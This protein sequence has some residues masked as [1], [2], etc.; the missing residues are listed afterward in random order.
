M[1]A[2]VWTP[3]KARFA[4]WWSKRDHEGKHFWTNVAIGV[5]LTLVLHVAE[6]LGAFAAFK[7]FG[8]DWQIATLAGVHSGPN[9]ALI[10]I[11][12]PSELSFGDRGMPPPF[13]TPRDKLARLIAAAVNAGAAAVVVDIDLSEP[14]GDP[15]AEAYRETTG[16]SARGVPVE[17]MERSLRS[18]AGKTASL[19][20][21]QRFFYGDWELSEFLRAYA[22]GCAGKPF[23]PAPGSCV[24]VILPRTVGESTAESRVALPSFLDGAIGANSRSVFWG[25]VTFDHDPDFVVRRWRLW[26]PACTP[27]GASGV[28]P[29]SALLAYAF[30]KPLAP[31]EAWDYEGQV[32]KS[33]Q[34]AFAPAQCP[35]A[36]AGGAAAVPKVREIDLKVD[37]V[38]RTLRYFI[39][40]NAANATSS[41][42]RAV[43]AVEV[44]GGAKLDLAC[45]DRGACIRGNRV[46]VIGSTYRNNGDYH[47]IPGG[48][49]PGSL[50]LLNEID[51]LLSP[52]PVLQEAR[53]PLS[54]GLDVILIVALSWAFLRWDPTAVLIGA[55]VVTLA[56]LI[57][58]S[59]LSLESGVW[60]DLSVP[61]IG[62]QIHEWV[63]RAEHLRLLK[64]R[65]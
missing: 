17:T 2:R 23:P 43:P 45:P 34:A 30:A 39:S 47:R 38:E 49:M 40:W 37:D 62:I 6:G 3:G 32:Y 1:I 29:A 52:S 21:V 55:L 25:S 18:L 19:D 26:E 64:R 14:R 15:L 42:E 36:G 44:L 35:F 9:V 50:V 60:F 46:V 31:G 51:S 20:A 56:G 10:D 4:D 57:A 53:W 5:G 12:E 13:F 28:L 22:S 65:K 54:F 59:L 33:L 58:S 61:C 63:T 8:L 16:R 41:L 11:D 7:Q 24:P 27:S 48:E